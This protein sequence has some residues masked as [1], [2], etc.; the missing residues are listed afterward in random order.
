[1]LQ[2]VAVGQSDPPPNL[3]IDTQAY[4]GQALDI[5]AQTNAGWGGGVNKRAWVA[6]GRTRASYR[7]SDGQRMLSE[8][9][10]FGLAF[11][12]PEIVI[13][14]EVDDVNKRLWT[15]TDRAIYFQ[16]IGNHP[17]LPNATPANPSTAL[18]LDLS[19]HMSTPSNATLFP[20]DVHEIVDLKLSPRA[21]DAIA[22]VLTT[23]NVFIV[24]WN[25]AT[26]TLS[27]LG[28]ADELLANGTGYFTPPDNDPIVADLKIYKFDRIRVLLDSKDR[29]MAFITAEMQG[30][31]PIEKQRPTPLCVVACWLDNGG[32]YSDPQFYAPSQTSQSQ[33]HRLVYYNAIGVEPHH[34]PPPDQSLVTGFKILTHDVLKAPGTGG[35][36]LMYVAGG[37]SLQARSM[38]VSDTFSWNSAP[39]GT[40][41]LN[42]NIDPNPSQNAL[43]AYNIFAD[44]YIPKRFYVL[45]PDGMSAVDHSTS[46]P[47]VK[48]CV[49]PETGK[50]EFVGKGSHR[51][52][53]EVFWPNFETPYTIWVA[54][55][56]AVDHVCKVFDVHTIVHLDNN[57]QPTMDPPTR[58]MEFYNMSSS[59]GGVLIGDTT[60]TNVYL[61][62]FGGVVRYS[63]DPTDVRFKAELTSFVSAEVNDNDGEVDATEHIDL[64]TVPLPP[65]ER[66]NRLVTAS[67]RGD[68]MEFKIDDGDKNPTRP[69]RVKP[70]DN[71]A[72]GYTWNYDLGQMGQTISNPLTVIGYYGNDVAF[73]DL[74]ASNKWVL[75]DLTRYTV[76][77]ES[78]STTDSSAEFA[79]LAYK[80]RS[81]DDGWD[82]VTFAKNP[83]GLPYPNEAAALTGTIFVTKYKDWAFVG[84]D[85][86]VSSFNIAGLAGGSPTMSYGHTVGIKSAATFNVNNGAFA[87]AAVQWELQQQPGTP[88]TRSTRVFAWVDGVPGSGTDT[89]R[90][91]RMYDLNPNNGQL[92]E[93]QVTGKAPITQLPQVWAYT[94]GAT[95]LKETAWRG[96]VRYLDL[97]DP[98]SAADVFFVS[99][100]VVVQFRWNPVDPDTL[101]YKGHWRSYRGDN[102][103]DCRSYVIP[104][105]DAIQSTS[106]PL[107]R[108]L[109]V[110]NREGFAVI[111][112]IP[113]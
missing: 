67:R 64:V 93:M 3:P 79:L 68:F 96:R 33:P 61:P 31:Y 86:G 42:F 4:D 45:R 9:Q 76:T 104:Q 88:P 89:G 92:T 44:R 71:F 36:Y 107:H 27:K 24:E 46:N 110:H 109:A 11:S 19:P 56:S 63:L 43:L 51:D 5:A 106:S 97:A 84:S 8:D 21:G 25:P 66:P 81:L 34:V 94:S 90:Q 60:S 22:F 39:L 23:F 47:I 1:M 69:R 14:V 101:E 75:T 58:M 72:W 73:L 2:G 65:L 77:F 85:I 50:V 55:H 38:D 57:N 29:V 111:Q 74:G 13:A 100:S 80:W 98:M 40:G 26:N 99:A 20:D 95:G 102:M 35:G 10:Q 62:T 87:V 48:K 17:P 7:L 83:T 113:Q 6:Q 105:L 78:P 52:V 112:A 108:V 70:I 82:F 32:N 28:E 53:A 49:A 15:V 103:Q 41:A 59:D 16:R 37:L 12:N 18:R 54:T 91:I 30:Y